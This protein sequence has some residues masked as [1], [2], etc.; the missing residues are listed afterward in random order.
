MD[1]HTT[2]PQ[3]ADAITRLP[4]PVIH[5]NWRGVTKHRRIEPISIRYGANLPHHP[6]PEWLLYARDPDIGSDGAYRAFAL[7]GFQAWGEAAVARAS[8]RSPAEVVA[9]ELLTAI[10]RAVEALAVE[11]D[12][13]PAAQAALEILADAAASAR[14]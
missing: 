3:G 12:R 14:S 6:V 11:A 8:L 4:V 9:A 1:S 5:C 7:A 10:D 13:S 2:T